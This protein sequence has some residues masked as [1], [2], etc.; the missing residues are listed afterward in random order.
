MTRKTQTSIP[1]YSTCILRYSTGKYGLAGSV[2]ATLAS[3]TWDTEAA[4]IAALTEIGHPFFQRADCTWQPRRPT[5]E[6]DRQT[7]HDFWYA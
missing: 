6:A 7:L 2:P 1:S 5:T 4:A 3:S